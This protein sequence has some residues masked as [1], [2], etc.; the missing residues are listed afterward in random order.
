VLDINNEVILI[1]NKGAMPKASNKVVLDINNKIILVIDKGAMPDT[2]RKVAL[3]ISNKVILIASGRAMPIKD[4]LLTAG[5]KA[6]PGLKEDER[7]AALE[8]PATTTRATMPIN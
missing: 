8:E 3:I 2:S 5:N 1:V 4:E 6:R 7:P